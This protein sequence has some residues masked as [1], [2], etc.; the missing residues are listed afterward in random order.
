LSSIPAGLRREFPRVT[1]WE[2]RGDHQ[3]RGTAGQ[4]RL[5]VVTSPDG[6]RYVSQKLSVD[7]ERD[8]IADFDA[9]VF[10]RLK[11]ARDGAGGSDEGKDHNE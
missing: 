7:V 11:R 6:T 3:Y 1:G 10:D 9:V 2:R 5:Y 8:A 4:A